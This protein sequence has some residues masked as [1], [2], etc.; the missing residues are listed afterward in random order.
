MKHE[1]YNNRPYFTS[2]ELAEWFDDEG[3]AGE[4]R[5]RDDG[6][7]SITLSES[8]YVDGTHYTCGATI[9]YKEGSITVERSQR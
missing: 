9:F 7:K 1:T 6:S 3:N 8:F 5:Q 4:Y 2:E